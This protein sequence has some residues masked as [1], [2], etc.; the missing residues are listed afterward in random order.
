MYEAFFKIIKTM[1]N[2][3]IYKLPAVKECLYHPQLP[4]FRRMD[5]DTAA[6]KLPD[7]HCRTTA[8]CGSRTFNE[9]KITLYKPPEKPLS[10]TSVTE[11]GRSLLDNG[12]SASQ[13][14]EP[15]TMQLPYP[16]YAMR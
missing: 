15:K 1:S 12:A 10:C 11:T 8:Q 13:A 3:G 7:Q 4:T 16:G 9:A 14:A 2:G 5:I 6:H